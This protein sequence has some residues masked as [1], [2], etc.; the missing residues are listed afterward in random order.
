MR[1]TQPP[2][3]SHTFI[4]HFPSQKQRKPDFVLTQFTLVCEVINENVFLLFYVKPQ[5][6]YG[7]I[8]SWLSFNFI[9]ICQL[10]EKL[11]IDEH[12]ICAEMTLSSIYLY[13]T[14]ELT[15]SKEF[16]IA[17]QIV[18]RLMVSQKP[19]DNNYSSVGSWL[20]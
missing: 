20:P 1:M 13:Y 19:W 4:I 5:H 16:H 9:W 14:Q 17:G 3:L 11:I 15:I 12:F 10:R 18:T 2:I 8:H 6:N 7:I